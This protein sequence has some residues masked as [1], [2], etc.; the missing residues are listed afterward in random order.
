MEMITLTAYLT[1]ILF[2]ELV[3]SK[4]H[5]STY[6]C[7]ISISILVEKHR[8]SLYLEYSTWIQTVGI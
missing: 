6:S 4:D 5:Y 2:K 1:K 3:F 7:K 8:K